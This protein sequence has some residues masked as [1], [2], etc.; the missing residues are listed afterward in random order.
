MFVCLY[1]IWHAGFLGQDQ[2]QVFGGSQDETLQST[3]CLALGKDTELLENFS[4]ILVE[5]KILILK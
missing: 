3:D 1:M 2:V 5:N 4:C